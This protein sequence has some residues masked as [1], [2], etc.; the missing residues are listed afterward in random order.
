MG[1][2]RRQGPSVAEG[3]EERGS[4]HGTRY[5]VDQGLSCDL[6]ILPD[7]GS[8]DTVV[9]AEKGLLHVEVVWRG[10]STGSSITA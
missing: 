9:V 8:I 4:H 10:A 7:G 1:A 6:A 5:L 2:G 3:D